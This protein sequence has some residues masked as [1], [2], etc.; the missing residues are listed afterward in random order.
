[1]LIPVRQQICFYFVFSF[2]AVVWWAFLFSSTQR[3][4][5]ALAIF[6][7]QREFLLW[8][9]AWLLSLSGSVG[10]SVVVALIIELHSFLLNSTGS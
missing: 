10:F 1:M 7:T 3:H 2:V 4:D 6:N 5:V 8:R 9:T